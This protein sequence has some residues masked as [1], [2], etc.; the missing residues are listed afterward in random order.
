MDKSIK[1][2]TFDFDIKEVNDDGTTGV[3]EG[4][5]STFGNVDLGND[6][7]VKGA[8]KK[9]IKDNMKWPILA[10]HNPYTPVGINTNA[11]EDNKGLYVK[12]ELE[13]G[14][15]KAKERYLLAKQAA[16]HG[17]RSGLSIGYQIVKAEPAKDAP[18]VLELKEL[19]MYEYSLVTFPMNTEALVTGAKSYGCIDK[20]DFLLKHL[21]DN[22]ISLKDL[23]IALKQRAAQVEYDPTQV[24]QSIDNLIEKFKN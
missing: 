15:E 23:E 1:F 21:F 3:I 24:S 8:F 22:E 4:Y 18:L 13:L 10:D 16:R 17:G 9:T 7:V 12:G 6:R 5:A 19:K 11:Y 20:V 14:V 2:K